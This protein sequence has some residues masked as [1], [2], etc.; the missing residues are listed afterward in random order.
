MFPGVTEPARATM[1]VL[2]LTPFFPSVRNPAQGG[3]IAEPL[4]RM[5]QF[6]VV[7]RVIATQPFYRGREQS[8]DSR[9]AQWESF[10]ALPGNLGLSTAG[11]LLAASLRRK[12]REMNRADPVALIHAHSA[13]PCGRAAQLLSEELGIPFV[14]TVHGLDAF[15]TRQ[16]GLVA[17]AWCRMVAKRVYESAQ[18]VICISKKVRDEVLLGAQAK[19]AVIYNGVDAELFSPGSES[20]RPTIILSVGNLIPIKD[21]ALLLQAFAGAARNRDCVL[22]IIGEGPE[23]NN[24]IGLAEKLGIADRVHFLGRKSRQEVAD[25]MRRCAIFALPSRYEGQGCVYLEAM[26]SGKPAIGCAG[27]GI[28]EIIEHQKSGILIPPGGHAALTKSLNALLDDAALRQK[29]GGSARATVLRSHTLTH[30][31]QQL[32]ELYRRC[33]R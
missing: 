25:A 8:L 15:F 26:A 17:G 4:S 10:P 19:T 22:E 29:I 21:H 33:A 14:V 18:S 7:S 11:G 1:R 32:S 27:Q 3:F 12:V 5:E 16:S 31:A 24:L 28:E 9:I 2:T 30:Q 23:R 20:Q 6:G 13:L